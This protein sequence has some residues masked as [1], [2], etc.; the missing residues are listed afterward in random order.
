M[1]INNRVLLL[2]E[3]ATACNPSFVKKIVTGL[4][5]L[6]RT[7]NIQVMLTTRNPVTMALV[8]LNCLFRVERKT[9]V[10]MYQTI[11]FK[12]VNLNMKLFQE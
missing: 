4:N 3:I 9:N 8:L 5:Y 12:N 10:D 2:D 6:V 7:L 11:C 1:K